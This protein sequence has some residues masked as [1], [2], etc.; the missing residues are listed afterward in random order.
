[1]KKRVGA[2]IREV[3]GDKDGREGKGREGMGK[4]RKK[5]EEK[6]EIG[7]EERIIKILKEDFGFDC[8]RLKI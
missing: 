3:S 4:K 8:T 2:R 5:R 6:G 7:W 1:M